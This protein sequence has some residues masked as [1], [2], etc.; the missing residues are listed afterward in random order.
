M[1]RPEPKKR[2]PEVRF[3]T[4][5]FSFDRGWV[6]LLP[7]L[8][9]TFARGILPAHIPQIDPDYSWKLGIAGSAGILFSVIIHE[10]GHFLASKIT[11]SERNLSTIY[12]Y[13]GVV[14]G[15]LSSTQKGSRG[16]QITELAGPLSSLASALLWYLLLIASRNMALADGIGTLFLYLAYFSL[17]M[18]AFNLIPASPLDAGNIIRPL[19]QSKPQGARYQDAFTAVVGTLLLL[20]GKTAIFRGWFVHGIWF[21]IPGLYLFVAVRTADS[22][23]RNRNFLRGEKTKRYMSKNP[24][25]VPGA[26][27]IRRF[28]EEYIYRYNFDVF[29]VSIPAAP[30]RF[31]AASAINSVSQENW[32]ER[33]VSEFS[34][35]CTEENSVTGD[36][37]V[38]DTLEMMRT[39]SRKS[40][41]VTDREGNL[42]GV[43]SYKD[44]L[45]FLS[46]KIHLDENK[47][48]S[49][50]SPKIPDVLIQKEQPLSSPPHLP[51]KSEPATT[52]AEPES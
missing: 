38:I 21:I 30:V 37:D 20:S 22:R 1:L 3:R 42:E 24:V 8:T 16:K 29:P 7:L 9:W 5:I 11:K 34:V 44:L 43:V 36:T 18:A 15:F 33:K 49:Q 19:L 14:K 48:S 52:S 32:N 51:Y 17:L 6:L 25:C 39:T 28:V 23:V 40:I 12:L 50:I 27:T 13:G 45:H 26:I 47:S 2:A 35:L 31:I 41:I 10:M 4:A 46:L